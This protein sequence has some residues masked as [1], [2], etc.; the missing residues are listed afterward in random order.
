MKRI[1]ILSD[2][3]GYWD[4]R[5]AR[6]L[7]GC[8]AIFHC[9]DIGSPLIIEQLA[10]LAPVHAVHGNIDGGEM[11]QLYPETL[12][13]EIEKTRISLLHIG[14]Y[15]G[16]YTLAGKD[17]ITRTRPHLFLSGHSHILKVMPDPKNQLLHINPGAAGIQGW[18]PVRTLIRLVVD[19][20]H[21]RDLEVI[22]LSEYRSKG[23][24]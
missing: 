4:E 19:G 12:S 14:G 7:G 8:D 3:H 21:F 1:G 18:Q 23:T 9:G 24:D 11:R 10:T 22:E 2:T 6:Y 20:M 16:R 15:P 17:L 5:Y 13:V